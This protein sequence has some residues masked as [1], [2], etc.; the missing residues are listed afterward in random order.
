METVKDSI[1]IYYFEVESMGGR[2]PSMVSELL[3]LLPVW[4]QSFSLKGQP[5]GR[6]G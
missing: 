6:W 1:N 3:L 5:H 4:L 2:G